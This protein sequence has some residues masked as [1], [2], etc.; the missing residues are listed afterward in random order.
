VCVRERESLRLYLRLCV[1][2]CLSVCMNVCL[3]VCLYVC[4]F[5]CTYVCMYVCMCVYVFLCVSAC[6]CVCES[7]ACVSMSAKPHIHASHV[8][9]NHTYDVTRRNS[10]QHVQRVQ[11]GKC[12][13]RIVADACD[14]AVHVTATQQLISDCI[15]VIRT[16]HCVHDSAHAYACTCV[17]YACTCVFGCDINRVLCLLVLCVLCK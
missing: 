8:H 17:W 6:L 1:C 3:Y 5:V 13:K 14:D 7:G 15:A 12:I 2:V 11:R 16:Q 10:G 4:L 9:Q